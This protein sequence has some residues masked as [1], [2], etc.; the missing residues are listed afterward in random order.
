ML[1]VDVAD[2]KPQGVVEGGAK[3]PQMIPTGNAN[4]TK[5]KAETGARAGEEEEEVEW[6]EGEQW[7]VPVQ[8]AQR[9]REG[10]LGTEWMGGDD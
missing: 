2:F 8:G 5:F 9:F 4:L 7:Q 1:E 6:W 10:Q 3:E